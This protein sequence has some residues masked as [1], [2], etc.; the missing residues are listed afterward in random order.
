MLPEYHSHRR[1]L[2]SEETLSARNIDMIRS[3]I[4]ECNERH[5][6]CEASQELWVPSRLLNIGSTDRLDDLRLVERDEVEHNSQYA[7]LSHMWGDMTSNPPT[8]TLQSNLQHMK[9]GI[10][11]RDISR[12]FRDAIKVCRALDIQYIWIDSLCIIQDSASDWRREAATMH[13][14]YRHAVVTFVAYGPPQHFQGHGVLSS[15]HDQNLGY[16]S[17]RWISR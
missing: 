6:Y 13:L 17:P 16:L 7:A 12:N 3:W 9:S 4:A 11:I 2:P 1:Q 10:D 15:D 8:R 5:P 14:V